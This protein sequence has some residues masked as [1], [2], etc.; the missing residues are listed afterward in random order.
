M[1]I[2]EQVKY[3]HLDA[4]ERLEPGPQILLGHEI[5]WTLKED[6]SNI[7]IALIDGEPEIR[8]RNMAR[9]NMEVYTQMKQCPEWDA[10]LDLLNS[11]SEWNTDYVLFGELCGKGKSPTRIKV[12]ENT[13]FIAFDLW[14]AKSQRFV[15]YTKLYQECDHAGLPVTE[16]MGTCKMTTI[17]ELYEFKDLMLQECIDRGEEGVVGKAMG[18]TPF[19]MGENAGAGRG[20]IYFKSKVDTPRLTKVPRDIRDGAIQLP[21]LSDSEIY[22]AIEKARVDLGDEFKNIRKAMPLIAQY[23]Q[24]ECKHHLCEG[25]RNLYSYYETRLK[26]INLETFI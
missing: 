13:H 24:V 2:L 20:T 6:G 15:N 11:A 14:S 4:L 17:E 19:N 23:V 21:P 18:E 7:G 8:S 16:L 25:P 3:P 12:H 22:G 9:A 1:D 5:F 26:D 10:I